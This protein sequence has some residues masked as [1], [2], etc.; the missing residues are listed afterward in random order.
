LA[1]ESGA[2]GM[3]LDTEDILQIL[4][5]F[6]TLKDPRSHINRK[7]LLGELMVICVASVLAG[8]EGP[9]AI[10]RWA[11]M[12]RTWLKEHLEL[13]GGIPSHDTIGRLLM[14]I[15]PAAFQACF[16]N[17]LTAIIKAKEPSLPQVDA[18]SATPAACAATPP[19]HLAVDGK[20]LRRSHDR[21]RGLGPLH[22]VSAWA[23]DYGV[24]LG[25]LA[26]EEKSNEITAI[27]E[28]LQQVELK[29]SVVTIDA[30]GCQ[31]EI[32]ATIVDGGG[33]FCL[34]LKGNQGNLHAAVVDYAEEQILNDF[35]DCQVE[36]LEHQEPKKHG[37][38]DHYTYYQFVAPAHLPGRDQWKKLNS[39]GVAI[40]RSQCGDKETV[41]VRFYITSLLLN[42]ALFAKIVR[43][44]WAIENTLHW[45]LDVTFREDDCR[46]RERNLTNNLAWLK[47]FAIS[48][49][50][51][52]KDQQS[53]AMRRRCCGWSDEYLAQVLFGK[54]A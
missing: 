29:G 38:Q 36:T 28:L 35:A 44:H 9:I 47:R 41:D 6:S 13:P 11:V 25:Q 37:R 2:I 14:V 12:K 42:V 20:T 51:Q 21:R 32:A 22:L 3:Q 24:S 43:G 40:R 8:C 15:R 5:H 26:T 19:R 50:K 49:L 23:V 39:I 1:L 33:D 46:V 10:G 17:W 54:E 53:V 27:P 18:D 34:A 48:L 52:V 30:M 31:K 45:C 7:H 16:A 4:D